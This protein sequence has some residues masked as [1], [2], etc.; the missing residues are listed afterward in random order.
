MS[1][2]RQSDPQRPEPD[3]LLVDIA[4]YVCEYRIDSELARETAFYCLMDTS[5]A[6]S[7]R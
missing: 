4:T 7:R 2:V 6:A 1:H 5:P 3:P